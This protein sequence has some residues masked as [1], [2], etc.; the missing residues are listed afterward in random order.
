ML[1]FYSNLS[2]LGGAMGPMRG[3]EDEAL[4]GNLP[5]ADRPGQNCYNF[6]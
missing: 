2:G 5:C 3:P 4:R 1:E 6:S